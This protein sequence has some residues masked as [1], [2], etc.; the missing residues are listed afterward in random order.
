MRVFCQLNFVRLIMKLLIYFQTLNS[1]LIFIFKLLTRKL[2]SA[3]IFKAA[4]HACYEVAVKY[5]L[6]IFEKTKFLKLSELT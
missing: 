4:I 3:N 2:F 6:Y 5:C 1:S